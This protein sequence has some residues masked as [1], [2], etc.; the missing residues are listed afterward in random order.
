MSDLAT[1]PVWRRQ[2]YRVFFPLG[3]LLG[4]AGVLHWL[5][6]ATDLLRDYRPLFHSIT[7][8]QG[9]MMCF[10]M[11]FLFTAIPRR[12]GTAP[13]A[14]WEMI[15][16]IV[17]PVGLT[18]AAWFESRTLP[19]VLWLVLVGVLLA[20]VQKR[21]MSD[22][23]TRKPPVG[24]IW[25]PIALGMGIA[26]SVMVAMVAWLG[27]NGLTIYTLGRL[28]LLQGLFIGLIAG[29]GSMILPLITRGES[30]TDGAQDLAGWLAQV[31]H[32]G[33]AVIL[34]I[35][36]W[37]E[38]MGWTRSGLGLRAAVVLFLL[39]GTA[40]I[41]RL[42][43]RAGWHRWLVWFSAWALPIGYAVAAVFPDQQK[44]GL[45]LVFIGGF[46]L[47]AL[48][49]AAHVT[50]AHGGFDSLV[51][52]R[53]WQVPLYGSLLLVAAALRGLV[54]FDPHGYFK[55]IG[56]S[57]AAFLLG[58]VFWAWLVVPKLLSSSRPQSG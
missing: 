12:T 42:P 47:M 18:I 46:T 13:P 10:A 24:F 35:S 37:I 50:L 2:P 36:F 21:L 6:H 17:L 28:F 33:A 16:G 55:W 29:V 57:S 20:F 11:G 45:H 43:T 30:S 39:V 52:G 54:D 15:A 3:L 4:W 40:K 49:V 32:I 27:A 56:L 44:A 1:S 9:F 38:N 14:A 26:G 53:P 25:I 31:G 5:L 23:A 7:Q 48:S 19:Q 8:I 58:T 41:W 22:E 34:V 51:N